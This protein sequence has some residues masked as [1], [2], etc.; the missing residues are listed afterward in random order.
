MSKRVAKVEFLGEFPFVVPLITWSDGFS[1]FLV[2]G[3]REK[4]LVNEAKRSGA[5]QLSVLSPSRSPLPK[6]PQL[7]LRPLTAYLEQVSKNMATALAQ[8]LPKQESSN[9]HKETEA[10]FIK[11]MQGEKKLYP[12][13]PDSSFLV[14]K[15]SICDRKE[16]CDVLREE[17]RRRQEEFDKM[18]GSR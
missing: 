14:T 11:R 5:E 10:E 18:Y 7:N 15:C 4:E 12:N 17:D 13:C 1:E 16:L 9:I 6:F 3:R 2:A 8:M